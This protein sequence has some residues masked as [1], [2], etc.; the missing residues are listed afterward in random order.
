MTR[1][2]CD[3]LA[4]VTVAGLGVAVGVHMA[5]RFLRRQWDGF[6]GGTP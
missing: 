2:I 3:S 5:G 1:K 6:L 4:W